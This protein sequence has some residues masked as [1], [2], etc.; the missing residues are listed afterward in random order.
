[1]D[2][3]MKKWKLLILCGLIIAAMAAGLIAVNR[4]GDSMAAKSE[5]ANETMDRMFQ[6]MG[7]LQVPPQPAPEG[8]QLEDLVGNRIT[9]ADYKGKIVFLNFWTTWCPPCRE[10]MPAMEKLHK[11]LR[12]E[13]F[14]VLAV[15]LKESS[16]KVDAF[17]KKQKLTFPALLDP[18]GEAGKQ[19]G[20]AQIPTTFILSKKGDII[21]KALGPRHWGDKTSID[22]FRRLSRVD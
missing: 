11:Q 9:L 21:G 2:S 10:E 22:F 17:F 4:S 1:M 8:I 13:N 15:S 6:E 18:K 19:F 20:I 16:K 5:A 3:D 12:K 14:V 7:V